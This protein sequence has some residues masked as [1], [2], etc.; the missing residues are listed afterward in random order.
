MEQTNTQIQHPQD[1]QSQERV[2]AIIEQAQAAGAGTSSIMKT[3]KSTGRRS[4]LPGQGKESYVERRMREKREQKE[5]QET[6]ALI[7]EVLD[8][9]APINNATRYVEDARELTTKVTD[10]SANEGVHAALAKIDEM[11]NQGNNAAKELSKRVNVS[12]QAFQNDMENSIAMSSNLMIKVSTLAASTEGKEKLD[13]PTLQLAAELDAQT[14]AANWS[15]ATM[16]G[17]SANTLLSN[18]NE[19]V[20]FVE[21]QKKQEATD[22]TVVTDVQVKE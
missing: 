13:G 8:I 14:S 10:L 19:A 3:I 22:V 21:E 11:A 15:L 12:I 16:Y 17:M 2:Q 4:V 1:S 7:N 18:L 20:T 6:I 9:N 5:N